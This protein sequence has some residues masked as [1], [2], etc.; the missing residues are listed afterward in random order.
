[1]D[2]EAWCTACDA[3]LMKAGC[4]I[5]R[6]REREMEME[7]I[8]DIMEMLLVRGVLKSENATWISIT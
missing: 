2:G 4:I 1:M 7:M 8:G 3:D 6:R 5:D